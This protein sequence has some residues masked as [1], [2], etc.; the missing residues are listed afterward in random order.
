M[1]MRI[2]TILTRL[3]VVFALAALVTVPYESFAQLPFEARELK[4]QGS[5]AG[6]LSI[7]APATV[8]PYTITLPN[9]AGGNGALLYSNTTNGG[10]TWTGAPAGTGYSLRWNGTAIEWVDPSG[11]NNP[12]WSL[13]GN[14]LGATGVL[15]SSTNQGISIITNNLERMT[16]ASDG[17]IGINNGTNAGATTNIGKAGN[18]VNL[19][20]TS[21]LTGD[22]NINTTTGSFAT[23]IGTGTTAGTVTIGRT[24]GTITT[25]GTLGH[26][27]NINM[28][29]DVTVTGNINL[30]G[31]TRELQMN[32][33]AGAAGSVLVSKGTGV[34]PEWQSIN[35]A[36]GIRGA[37]LVATGGSVTSFAVTGLTTLTATDAI[38]V[39]IEGST[40]VTATVTSRTAG[41]GFTVT[42]SG[43]YSGN[44]SY[45]VLAAQ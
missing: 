41:T 1:H 18:T 7:V 4:L 45:M 29:G 3:R 2:T 11:A 40:S 10:L 35:S 43:A 20:G 44:F 14:A 26:T 8:T 37:A 30:S 15:G 32:G 31:T 9:A 24:G 19:L 12:N 42:F 6:T 16:V 34:T 38:L 13:T 21:N 36:I 27:G 22:A 5:S 39:T 28:G 23:N 17:V 33:A 25:V